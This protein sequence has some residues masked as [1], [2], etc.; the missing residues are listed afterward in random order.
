M[1]IEQ[2]TRTIKFERIG[3]LMASQR[4]FRSMLGQFIAV[5]AG[6][7]GRARYFNYLLQDH[8]PLSRTPARHESSFEVIYPAI[9]VLRSA[10]LGK[11]SFSITAGLAEH[12]EEHNPPLDRKALYQVSPGCHKYLTARFVHSFGKDRLVSPRACSPVMLLR[13]CT[14][15]E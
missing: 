6:E 7:K 4:G 5:R 10:I 8:P 3:Q 9:Q 14:S 12:I 15:Q 11:R 2:S 13:R 1:T